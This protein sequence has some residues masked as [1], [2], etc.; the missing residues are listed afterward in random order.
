MFALFVFSATVAQDYATFWPGIES[1]PIQVSKR[2]GDDDDDLPPSRVTSTTPPYY[3]PEGKGESSTDFLD[4]FYA[5]CGTKKSCFGVPSGCE[6]SRNCKAITAVTVLGNRYVFEIK[7]T[8]ATWVGVGLS[9]D[10][11]M[12]DDSVIECVKENNVM[13]AYYSWTNPKKSLGAKRLPDVS[14][15][16]IS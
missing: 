4:P 5:D 14:F 7:A 13:K 1:K 9:R 10:P 8:S 3:Q 6:N 12:G 2:A 16:S 15:D 11:T